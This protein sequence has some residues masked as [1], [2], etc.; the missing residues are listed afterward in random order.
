MA[1]DPLLND[2]IRFFNQGQYFEAHEIWEDLWRSAE[3]P[4]RNFYQGLI[5]AAVGLHHLRRKNVTG[6]RSQLEK[7]LKNLGVFPPICCGIDNAALI[8]KLGKVLENLQ[9]QDIRILTVAS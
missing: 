6:A 9:V 5:H 2:G 3:G 7:S 8:S 4:T 1:I